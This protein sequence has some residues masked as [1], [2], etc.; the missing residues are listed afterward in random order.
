[1]RVIIT[2][3]S[4]LLAPLHGPVRRSGLTLSRE[5]EGP[6]TKFS[7]TPKGAI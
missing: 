7:G 1:V 2:A 5:A 6:P 4:L 3:S